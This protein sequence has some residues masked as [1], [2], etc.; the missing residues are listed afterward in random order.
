[1][2]LGIVPLKMESWFN[3]DL[4]PVLDLLSL[5]DRKGV[6]FVNL[7]EHILMGVR[8]LDKYPYAPPELRPKLFDERTSFYETTVYLGAIASVTQRMRLSTGVML[9]PL[10][11]ATLLAKQLATLDRLSNGRLEIGVGTGWQRLEYDAEGL[12][13]EGRFGRMTEIAKACKVLW[14]Q[15]PATFHGKHVNFDDV[16]SLP[17]PVQQGGIPQ[18]FGIGASERNIERMAE[19]ADGWAAFGQSP[20]VVVSTMAKIKKRMA[21]LG[22]DPSKFGLRM[23]LNPVYIDGRADLDATLSVIPQLLKIGATDL[24][25]LGIVFCS[26]AD[27]FEPF[28]DKCLSAKYR[29]QE[30]GA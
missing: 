4:R 8:D 16:Y 14:T 6:D 15:A 2:K 22:R 27:E 24:D 19:V 20:D 30:S 25:I 23:H 26:T 28:I 3:E 9:S 18:W 5:A 11:T 12:P 7:A 29:Y 21:E 1:M 17:F 10:R 13:W